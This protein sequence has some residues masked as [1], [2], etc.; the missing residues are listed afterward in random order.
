M[1]DLEKIKKVLKYRLDNLE[2]FKKSSGPLNISQGRLEG[3][4]DALSWALSDLV[5][6][7]TSEELFDW[8]YSHLFVEDEV[9]NND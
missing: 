6:L 2:A 8:T 9:V 1:T 4:L 3:Q 7:Q 5:T